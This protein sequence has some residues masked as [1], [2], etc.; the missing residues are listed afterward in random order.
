MNPACVTYHYIYSFVLT[1]GAV[2]RIQEGPSDFH[3]RSV[4]KARNAFKPY[5][6]LKRVDAP[7]EPDIGDL[8]RVPA[9]VP[10]GGQRLTL[11][12]NAERPLVVRVQLRRRFL[13]DRSGACAYVVEL[14]ILQ[15]DCDAGNIIRLASL[16]EEESAVLEKPDEPPPTVDAPWPLPD[17]AAGTAV[18]GLYSLFIADVSR[19]V[20]RLR[21]FDVRFD[22][23][24]EDREGHSLV[25][26]QLPF[27]LTVLRFDRQEDYIDFL[28]YDG[29]F[30]EKSSVTLEVRQRRFAAVLFRWKTK[31]TGEWE[32]VDLSYIAGP[33]S[34][35][36]FVLTNAN[37]HRDIYIA[38]NIRSC[39]VACN[40]SSTSDDG[41][42][43]AQ[44][45]IG[46][47]ETTLA[48]DRAQWHAYL[49]VNAM[50][51]QDVDDLREDVRGM[52]A[53]P[54]NILGRLMMRKS[55]L[56]KLLD[57]TTSYRLASDTLWQL[58]RQISHSLGMT[59]LREQALG[60]LGLLDS[61]IRTSQEY[62]IFRQS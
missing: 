20:D 40:I 43:L 10:D 12:L 4:E 36:E 34:H 54:E 44:F 45:T 56:L 39:V 59:D 19:L 35:D 11:R 62:Y 30:A 6:T 33:N 18:N 57:S 55:L 61:L 21:K 15:Q 14:A 5:L 25:T 22:W 28:P 32:D 24:E 48:A 47:L 31:K 60:K 53:V 26:A 3:L 52:L 46:D 1:G 37:V 51:D 49:I 38:S 13:L 17:V 7:L 23:L 9:G 50:L 42:E 8:P 29:A 2:E 16:A 41:R 27:V 58:H